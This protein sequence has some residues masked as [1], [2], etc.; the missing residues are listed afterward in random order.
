MA[1]KTFSKEYNIAANSSDYVSFGSIS[2][3]GYIVASVT[4]M[5]DL[6]TGG[7]A[8]NIT[9][10][11]VRDNNDAG[12]ELGYTYVGLRNNSPTNA[13]SGHVWLRVL[14]LKQ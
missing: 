1:Y 11:I 14:Y 13:F 6:T 9:S 2:K 8:H 12:N 3:S 7:G 5:I 10:S 4:A